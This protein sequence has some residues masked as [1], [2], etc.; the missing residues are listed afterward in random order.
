MASLTLDEGRDIGTAAIRR[1]LGDTFTTVEVALGSEGRAA[2]RF[3]IR[4]PTE[5]S[6]RRA[7]AHQ[8]TMNGAII[9]AL[10][11]RDEERSDLLALLL[12]GGRN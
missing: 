7:S 10:H 4:F 9:D 5:Q 3:T 2:S 6:W 12:G 1:V 11:S 8:A